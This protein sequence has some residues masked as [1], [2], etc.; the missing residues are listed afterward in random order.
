[1]GTDGRGVDDEAMAFEAI[2]V[3]KAFWVGKE[4]EA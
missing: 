3:L 4:R 2:V 1:V